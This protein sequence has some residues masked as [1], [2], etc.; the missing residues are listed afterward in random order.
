MDVRKRL[1]S[2][3]TSGRITVVTTDIEGFSGVKGFQV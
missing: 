2:E 1:L 3:P